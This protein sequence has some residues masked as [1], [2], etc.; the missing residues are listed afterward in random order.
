MRTIQATRTLRL[1]E[2]T[3]ERES[4]LAELVTYNAAAMVAKMRRARTQAVL[5]DALATVLQSRGIA[6]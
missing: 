2:A 5:A 4:E 1:S 6:S 3:E